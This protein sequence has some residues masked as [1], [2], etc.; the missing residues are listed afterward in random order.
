MNDFQNFNLPHSLTAAIERMGYTTPTPIQAK[1][2]PLVLDG[3]DVLASSHTGSGK[4]GAF[5][6]PLVAKMLTS[7]NDTALILTPTREL[8]TQVMAIV[9][10]LTRNQSLL[11]TALLIGGDSLHKQYKQLKSFPRIVVGTP[12]RVNDHLKRKTLKLHHNKFLVLDE[13]DR[14]LDMGF[15]VQIDT[16]LKHTPQVRQTLMFSATI[17]KQIERLAKNYLTNPEHVKMGVDRE[18]APNIVQKN[19]HVADRDKYATLLKEIQSREGSILVFVGTKHGAQKIADRLSAEGHEALA[20]HGDLRQ[21]QRDRVMK[22]FH[23]QRNRIMIATDVASRGLDVPHIEHVINYDL[24]QMDEDYIHRIGRT[25]RAGRSGS[26]LSFISPKDAHKWR[27]IERML[28]GG[29]PEPLVKFRGRTGSKVGR[30]NVRSFSGPKFSRTSG[31]E[32]NSG[33]GFKH[34]RPR[35]R[36]HGAELPTNSNGKWNFSRPKN[37]AGLQGTRVERSY[38]TNTTSERPVVQGEARRRFN[39]FGNSNT[40]FSRSKLA[41]HNKPFARKSFGKTSKAFQNKH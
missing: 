31:S 39:K 38:F 37:K 13:T 5:A 33:T 2:S 16:I 3:K 40:T 14:M 8:A 15:G 7:E 30:R 22:S 36:D 34:R 11:R 24:P 10:D 28:K 6:I 21:R 4:T 41:S 26:S 23:G 19:I 12:G 32:S 27:S 1:V 29:E 20:I 18:V 35:S 25:A 17:S 9:R